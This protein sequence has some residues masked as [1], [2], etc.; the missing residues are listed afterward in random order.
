[1]PV[2]SVPKNEDNLLR[3]F[4]FSACP[5]IYEYAAEF[6]VEHLLLIEKISKQFKDT[7]E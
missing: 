6:Y 5:K 1:M 7:F 2:H 3:A 4:S